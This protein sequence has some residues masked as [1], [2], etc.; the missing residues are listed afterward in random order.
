MRRRWKRKWAVLLSAAMVISAVNIGPLYAS[1]DEAGAIIV[2]F[3]G[4]E[5][6]HAVQ[7][8]PIGAEETDIEFPDGLWVDLAA[9]TADDEDA[10]VVKATGS[11][12]VEIAEKATGSNAA[13]KSG[14][15]N[16]AGEDEEDSGHEIELV[17]DL[18]TGTE[19]T[20]RKKLSD[21]EWILNAE[22]STEQEFRSDR[23]GVYT[24]EP[25]IPSDYEV[26]PDAVIPQV[27]VR[28]GIG[29]LEEAAVTGLADGIL[30]LTD[31]KGSGTGWSWNGSRLDVNNSFT[32]NKQIVFLID[33]AATLKL[34]G[35]NA[36]LTPDDE[37]PAI[38]ASGD[39]TIT[40]ETKDPAF[41]NLTVK[42]SIDAANVTITGTAKVAADGIELFRMESGNS[43]KLDGGNLT[44]V[45][46]GSIY[47]YEG[48]AVE[49]MAGVFSDQG[50]AF[51]ENGA[52]IVG[53]E[54]T[55]A[56]DNQLTEGLYVGSGTVF[57]KAAGSELVSTGLKHGIL[58]ITEQTG[59]VA[60]EG[61]NWNGSRL[62]INRRFVGNKRIEFTSD[63]TSP[64]VQVNSGLT[65]TPDAGEPAITAV[66]DMIITTKDKVTLTVKGFIKADEVTV[67]GT[68]EI[69]ADGCELFHAES[70]E[71]LKREGG[72]LTG[73]NGGSI[74]LSE[75]AIVEGMA[76]ILSDQGKAFTE[77]GAVT[78]GAAD[79][80]AAD[81]QLTA[82]SYIGSGS[83]FAK[84]GSGSESATGLK[85]GILTITKEK[86]GVAE[87]GW[88]WNG[89]KLDV[90]SKFAGNKQIVFAA[91]LTPTI[92]VNSGLTITPDAGKPAITAA[93]D[94]T[95]NALKNMKLKGHIE[96]ANVTIKGNGSGAVVADGTELFHVEAGNK[97]KLEGGNLTSEKG[98]SIYLSEGA[99]VEGMADVL[100]DQGKAFTEA[101]AA[102]VKAENTPAADNQLTAGSY[103]GAGSIF[104]KGGSGETVTTG[105][106]DGILTI[107]KEKGGVKE[108]GWAW[109]GSRLDVNDKF[110]GNKQIVFTTG[111]APTIKIN[112]GITLTPDSGKPAITA[113]GDLTIT[114]DTNLKMTAGGSIEAKSLT[115]KG[116]ANVE[117]YANG[118]KTA[119]FAKDGAISVS[120]A[121]AVAA[122]GAIEA[123]G[124]ITIDGSANVV[125]KAD[126][127]MAGLY[128]NQGTI[129]IS[130][131]A[132]VIASNQSGAAMNPAPDTS[133]YTA[134]R[135]AASEHASGKPAAEYRGDKIASYHYVK[136]EKLLSR[137]EIESSVENLDA[138]AAPALVDALADQIRSLP[139]GERT[140]LKPETIDKV[141]Q[142][143]QEAT[144]IK[145]VTKI[146]A[147][148][149]LSN[150][151]Q[152]Q[153][154]FIR[155]GLLAAGISSTDGKDTQIEL[156]V[157]QK[158][159]E[160]KAVLTFTC[161]LYV[162]GSKRNLNVPIELTI[163]L[164]PEFYPVNGYQI[165]HTGEGIDEW[166]DFVYH[167]ADN[168][169]RFRVASFSTF[170]IVNTSASSGGGSGSGGSGGGGGGGG[171]GSRS[172]AGAAIP[173]TEAGRWI[174][175]AAGWWY[176]NADKSYPKDG[177]AKIR[178]AGKD[179]WYFFDPNG[180]MLT[181][182][183]LWNGNWYYLSTA[184]DGTSGIMLTGWQTID[185]KRYYF[186]E[187]IDGTAG[188]KLTNIWIG[189]Y[190]LGTDGA[191]A[192][193]R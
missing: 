169:T 5:N 32:G 96:A 44:S 37:K 184:A 27:V 15:E 120:D 152:I 81:N 187:A 56:A 130:G 58:T 47:L 100:S 181:G 40:S 106:K 72:S 2:G 99:I 143:L 109:N 24:Y 22:E 23:A 93:G 150:S 129:T 16:N 117:A 103:V 88:N 73:I 79:A 159:P 13:G 35:R 119:F 14:W 132:T 177:W 105:L 49:G 90:N 28:V 107:T 57:T 78:V 17:N 144:A 98:G 167:G 67:K 170:S 151:K 97:L 26:D 157:V 162:N 137:E 122:D 141:D 108:E 29:L 168:T 179:E 160:N 46:D 155:G 193:K 83:I 4:L 164:P 91:D 163:E 116:S 85:D 48:A 51:T 60:E 140:A 145:V 133:N 68:G 34:N 7:T 80:P 84:G 76:G 86:G 176:Q 25:V 59:G 33:K 104:T 1:E 188:V 139:S 147:P 65:I 63:V 53:A 69:V 190:Y 61:W 149:G 55:E 74:Y 166:I 3:E 6:E 77:T 45:N 36:I 39:L 175:D 138:N 192:R 87:E 101:G 113:A 134:I 71:T 50:K 174:Q 110:T 124:N 64:T 62:D 172:L 156:R 127:P 92:Q 95:I 126:R 102:T 41:G 185:G 131:T 94:L 186:S 11:D 18:E 128:A 118:G 9:E 136:F 111:L 115:V 148:S 146:A 20:V 154:V 180:Y 114:A 158:Q 21:V 66:G 70:G 42:G 123:N 135:I 52:V 8:L 82:G 171:G 165:H 10:D 112:R 173:G 54:G 191:V 153:N 75:G 183:V 189:E 125:V 142:L 182:W 89:S 31:A 43:L 38:S 19:I 178:Y 121:A 12:A 161:D 30:T